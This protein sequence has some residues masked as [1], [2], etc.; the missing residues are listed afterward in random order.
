MSQDLATYNYNP[1]P[2]RVGGGGCSG[3]ETRTVRHGGSRLSACLVCITFHFTIRISDR[4]ILQITRNMHYRRSWSEMA[5]KPDRR[6]FYPSK[7]SRY[8]V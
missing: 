2:G 1:L 4:R 6:C 7:S 8:R 5:N 3:V